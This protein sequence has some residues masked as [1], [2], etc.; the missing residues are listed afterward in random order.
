MQDAA[1]LGGA[2]L[3]QDARR[4]VVRAQHV[5]DQRPADRA[6]GADVGAEDRLLGGVIRRAA[7]E[8]ALADRGR[9]GLGERARERVGVEPLAGAELRHDLRVDAER[10]PHRRVAR[11]ERAHRRPGAR[12]DGG[13][14]DPGHAGGGGALD[15]GVAVA[16]ERGVV[17]VA[18]R[19]DH[20]R[21]A[22]VGCHGV[23]RVEA[24]A[25]RGPR[26][27]A[28]RDAGARGRHGA[29][30]DH[31]RGADARRRRRDLRPGRRTRTRST[32]T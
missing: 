7:V 1:D 16:V 29:V 24:L 20:R 10:D 26:G 28:R 3:A 14:E 2:L 11:R 21:R 18:V 27:V 8:P 23:E 30:R 6:R 17:Q 12:P 9:A 32:R 5:D 31:R 19:V 25:A 4:G 13:Y 22:R 15:H